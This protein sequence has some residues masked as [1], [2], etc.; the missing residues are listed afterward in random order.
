MAGRSSA[1]PGHRLPRQS[2]RPS[3]VAKNL[4]D[5]DRWR[6][7][8]G[9]AGLHRCSPRLSIQLCRF[10]IQFL[11]SCLIRITVFHF[12]LANLQESIRGSFIARR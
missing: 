11:Q 8:T 10:L 6:P 5:S 12:I 7:Y 4:A 1:S 3:A 9:P 2:V